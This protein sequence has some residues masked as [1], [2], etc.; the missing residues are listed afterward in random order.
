MLYIRYLI[1]T[2]A[3]FTFNYSPGEISDHS[4]TAE[5]YKNWPTLN[6]N[7]LGQKK[8]A[9]KYC[10]AAKQMV[11]GMHWH[12]PHSPKIVAISF[13]LMQKLLRI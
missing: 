13:G 11:N 5:N 12:W 10:S 1:F 8:P 3:I 6:G 4:T 7:Y 2:F 9:Q